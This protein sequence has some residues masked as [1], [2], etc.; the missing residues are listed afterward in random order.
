MVLVLAAVGCTKPSG[1]DFPTFPPVTA[2]PV[3][4]PA[5]VPWPD[6]PTYTEA[7]YQI[8]AE[9]G[10]QFAIAM[11]ETLPGVPFSKSYDSARLTLVDDRVIAYPPDDLRKYGTEWFLFKAIKAGDTVITFQYPVEYTK[12]FSISIK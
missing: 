6:V 11:F 5:P 12:L 1:P 9:V 7:T 8:K 10:Q 4:S 2:R 3:P